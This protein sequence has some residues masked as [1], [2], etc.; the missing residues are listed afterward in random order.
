[1]RGK[2]T[3]MVQKKEYTEI[4]Y[5]ICGPGRLSDSGPVDLARSVLP[6]DGNIEAIPIRFNPKLSAFTMKMGGTTY[7]VTP[8]FNTEGR[9]SVLQQFKDLI[10]AEHC[11]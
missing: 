8:H 1:M 5:M 11:G 2:E 9:Q 10:L 7:E 3:A 6:P 4:P